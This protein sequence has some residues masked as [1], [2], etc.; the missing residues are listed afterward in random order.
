M[1]FH[2]ESI[3]KVVLVLMLMQ[4]ALSVILMCVFT[5]LLCGSDAACTSLQHWPVFKEVTEVFIL[6]PALLGLKG[7]LE[8][9]LASRL[10]TAVR[11]VTIKDKGLNCPVTKKTVFILAGD[12]GYFNATLTLPDLHICTTRNHP[13]YKLATSEE[14]WC[15]ATFCRMFCCRIVSLICGC[16]KY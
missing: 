7:N 14:R 3:L 15:L 5:V 6:V 8:M 2:I 11:H 1:T 16:V 9:T 10:S 13:G 4:I 12:Q